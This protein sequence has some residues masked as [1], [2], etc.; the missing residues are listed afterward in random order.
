MASAGSEEN[1]A[2]A[3]EGR[4]GDG[5]EHLTGEIEVAG[6]EPMLVEEKGAASERGRAGGRGLEGEGVVRCNAWGG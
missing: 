5:L 4:L 6:L 3:G 2:D 1:G